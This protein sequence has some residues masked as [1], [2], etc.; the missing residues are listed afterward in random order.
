MI[1]KSECGRCHWGR[2]ASVDSLPHSTL[3]YNGILLI[4][5]PCCLNLNLTT[6]TEISHANSVLVLVSFFNSPKHQPFWQSL[7]FDI[8]SLSRPTHQHQAKQ[9]VP[10]L[11]I[12][13]FCDSLKIWDHEVRFRFYC[14]RHRPSPLQHRQ[15][16]CC[17]KSKKNHFVFVLLII[18]YCYCK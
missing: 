5:S 2:S 18:V 11:L 14:I 15:R 1:F 8:L 13:I 6:N 10:L 16:W 4:D 3:Q 7:T 12:L 17:G 9:R